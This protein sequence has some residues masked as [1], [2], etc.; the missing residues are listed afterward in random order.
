MPNSM[1]VMIELYQNPKIVEIQLNTLRNGLV[2]RQLDLI[3]LRSKDVKMRVYL[4]SI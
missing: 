1:A 3:E 4:S 2:A